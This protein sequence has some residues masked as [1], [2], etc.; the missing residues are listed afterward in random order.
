M[1]IFVKLVGDY[2]K[3]LNY[4]DG[5][6]IFDQES[7]IQTRPQENKDFYVNFTE[8]RIFYDFIQNVPYK[9]FPF[10]NKLCLRYI[11][12]ITLSKGIKRKDTKIN[13]NNKDSS[14]SKPKRRGSF[15]SNSLIDNILGTGSTSDASGNKRKNSSTD[16]VRIGRLDEEETK[17][18]KEIFI[19]KPYFDDMDLI[20]YI[21]EILVEKYSRSC[22]K[23]I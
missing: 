21:D 18:Y 23:I 17:E 22:M 14:P 16:L 5:I 9:S 8:T 15:S 20:E 19:I 2:D 13:Q 12:E 10:F 6:P 4:I 3:Y 1:K 7:F 11:N